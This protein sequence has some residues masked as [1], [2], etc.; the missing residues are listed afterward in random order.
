[1][2]ERTSTASIGLLYAFITYEDTDNNEGFEEYSKKCIKKAIYLEEKKIQKIYHI[3]S[4]YV[5][6]EHM[7]GRNNYMIDDINV[8]LF[9]SRLDKS[10]NSVARLYISG[11]SKNEICIYLGI[12][13]CT[14][15]KINEQL[16]KSWIEFQ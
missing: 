1:M 16:R 7:H 13:E 10:K 12:T 6:D 5:F 3:E 14:L 15:N 9:L 11:Y 4:T 8:K 2:E